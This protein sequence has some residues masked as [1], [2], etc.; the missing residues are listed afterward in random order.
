M[1]QIDG[2]SAIAIIM[3]SSFAIERIVTGLLFLLSFFKPWTRAFPN[4]MIVSEIAERSSAEKKQRLIFFVFA[5]LLGI[6]V[7]AGY[8]QVRILRA[9]LGNENINYI[10]DT[11]VT[12]LTLAAG[13]DRIADLLKMHGAPGREKPET[14]PIEVIGKLILEEEAGKKISGAQKGS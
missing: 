14:R 10:L 8:G 4:P 3:I 12:G 11:I 9:V 2:V 6:P 7:L 1:S 5:C 13:S